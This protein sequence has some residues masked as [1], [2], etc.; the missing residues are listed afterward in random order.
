MANQVATGLALSLFGVGLSAF[1]G[2]PLRRASSS[3]ASAPLDD[4]R[5]SS[6]IPV[7][8]PLLFAHNPLVYLSLAAVRRRALV[9]VPHARGPRAARR[10]RVAAVRARDR[11]SGDRA[12]AI[13][14]RCSAARWPAWAARTCRSLYTP[15][16]VEGMT[17]GRGWIALAL[18]VFATWKPWRVL[19]GA[20]LF[21][22]V[23]LA[24]FQAQGA[25]RR[26]PVAV[27]V[28]AAVR[29]DDRR[30]GDHLARR[31]RDPPERAGVARQAVPP[32]RLNGVESSAASRHAAPLRRLASPHAPTPGDDD[33]APS[34]QTTLAA[35]VRAA[36]SRRA[37][38]P[39]PRRADDRSRSASST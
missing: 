19:V 15:L 11:L 3:R 22:G 35:L 5:C 31:D 2:M 18:V 39:P 26:R 21:G 13:S 20:Y 17:A 23:T 32:G 34:S 33:A 1:V 9:P 25:G 28:D 7:L 6:D 37:A 10:R 36:R 38:P 12:S 30:A 4:R 16:W 24:Q 14:R 8:G 29:R 27:P